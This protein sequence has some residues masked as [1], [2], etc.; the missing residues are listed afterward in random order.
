[1]NNLSLQAQLP[2]CPGNQEGAVI[3]SPPEMSLI[4]LQRRALAA[5]PRRV[6][7]STS[8]LTT[9]RQAG[10]SVLKKD[11]VI[12]LIDEALAIL[13]DLEDFD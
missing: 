4:G 11:R 9:R 7:T 3:T 2:S 10:A 5:F 1:M 13:D 6:I 8:P 12:A